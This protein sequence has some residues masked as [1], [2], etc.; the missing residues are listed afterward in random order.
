MSYQFHIV[1]VFAEKLY[2]GNP[3]AVVIGEVLP[4]EEVMQ[5]IAA[6]MNFSETTFVSPMLE[7]DGGYQVRIYT[8]SKELAFAGHPILGTAH[9]LRRQIHTEACSEIK[10][11]LM[12]SQVSVTFEL[13]DDGKEVVWFLAPE[14]KLGA[15]ANIE[16]VAHALGITSDD[17][18]T[19]APLQ[20]I[21][22]GTSAMIVPLR[23]LEVLRTCKL[24]L[25]RYSALLADG[26]PP[27]IYLF[28][29]QTHHSKNDLCARFFFEAH[30]V[31]EDPATGNGAAFLGAYL[32]E[33][34][35]YSEADLSLRIEQGYEVRRPSL[36]RLRAKID[37]GHREVL[38]GGNVL[39]V[40][41]G[42]LL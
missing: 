20:V 12:N 6:E 34:D 35:Y 39:S 29:Q 16:P 9:V 32:L 4:S 11:N 31:R 24:D 40:V 38:V 28:T 10:L 2:T 8:P 23:S 21:S 14:M 7:K 5:N 3:L 42:E 1:D 41:D 13:E 18:D 26:F 19:R 15:L 33:H 25:E 30:G 27:L 17:I 37:K 22:A 36:V